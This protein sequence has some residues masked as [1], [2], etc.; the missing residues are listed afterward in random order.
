LIR[1]RFF[2]FCDHPLDLFQQR[3]PYTPHSIRSAI[4][5]T[6]TRRVSSDGA[7][8]LQAF[9]E[10]AGLLQVDAAF[11]HLTASAKDPLTVDPSVRFSVC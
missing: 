6:A 11:Q 7:S 5:F 4:E 10:G 1:T 9:D 2:T 3:L 8:L